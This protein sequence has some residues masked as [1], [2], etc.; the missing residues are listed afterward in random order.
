MGRERAGIS[1]SD[2][3]VRYLGGVENSSSR[4][5]RQKGKAALNGL[6]TMDWIPRCLYGFPVS[7]V[8]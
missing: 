5:S 4:G 3:A 8:C 2:M 1:L 7:V 6:V